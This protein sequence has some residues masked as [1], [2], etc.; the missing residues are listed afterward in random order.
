MG[1]FIVKRLLISILIVFL[2]SI[3][4]FSLMQ[5]MPGDPARLALGFEAS[6]VDVQ[7]LREKMNL[8]KPV[9]EQYVI[10]VTNIFKGDFGESVIYSQPVGD[11]IK[12]RLPR[13]LT[14]GGLALLISAPLGIFF[15]VLCAVKRSK[16]I[17]KLLTTLMTIGLGMP[18]FWAGI[19][20]I[21]VFSIALHLLPIQGFSPLSEGF[22]EFIRHAILPVACMSLAMIA[23]IAGAASI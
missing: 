19:I 16:F 17:D 11:M 13:T 2:V 14:I 15:G 8:D 4:A 12:E 21:L 1:S 10:W 20:G 7:A 5:I 18:V 23:G 3:F 22:G 6:E 9:V